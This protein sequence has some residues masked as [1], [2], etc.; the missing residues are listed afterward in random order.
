M[1]RGLL[2]LGLA[3]ALGLGPLLA[4]SDT[5]PGWVQVTGKA[6]FRARDSSGEAT[7]R[8]RLWILGGWY[9]SFEDPPRD[10]W[11]SP[12][13]ATWKLEVKD[14]PFRHTDLPMTISFKDRLWFMGGWHGG[15][16]KHA[17]ASNEVWSSEDGTTWK[18]ATAAAGWSP[19]IAAGAVVFKDRM[20]ILGGVQ[21]YYFGDD[22]DLKN[23][24][25][26]SADGITWKQE[27]ARAPWA[28]RAYHAAVVHDGKLWVFGGG[29]YLPRYQGYNDVW[30]SPDGVNWTEVT[31]KA[32]WSPRIW[33]SAVA[34]RD[35]LWVLGGWYG[36]TMGSKNYNDVWIS[37]DGKSWKEFRSKS[38]W[39]GR[40]EHSAYIHRDSIYVA[41][42]MTPPLQN[43][44]WRLQLPPDW[45]K[46]SR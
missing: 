33:F 12:D 46:A 4:E 3:L 9:Q 43:D 29:N 35:H 36:P 2:L 19:R 17:S 27:T 18:Q 31:A 44:V 21:K 39:S 7:F 6:A 40:H 38:I 26:S 10:V 20:W 14:A 15:R 25:W 13:G 1:R 45:G 5:E 32:P 22:K 34:Y 24:V 42:G 30:S 37:R 16:L 23:D 28:P 8:D 11:S 41:A